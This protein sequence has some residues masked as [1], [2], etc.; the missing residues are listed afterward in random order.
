MVESFH[1]EKDKEALRGVVCMYKEMM[2]GNT[3]KYQ[4][5]ERLTEVGRF[6]S[7]EHRN[8]FLY[9]LL[10]T[11]KYE[12]NCKN[13]GKKVKDLTEHGLKE[14]TRVKHQ[15][16]IYTLKMELYDAPAGTRLLNKREA[17]RIS[18]TKKCYMK[19]VCEFL[20]VIWKWNDK[21]EARINK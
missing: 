15:R 12:R 11:A 5:D 21:Q 16:K 8:L 10:D 13:C 17:I 18:L 7:T 6:H 3:K 2:N 14:C 19:A 20:G 9:V 4:L 1:L